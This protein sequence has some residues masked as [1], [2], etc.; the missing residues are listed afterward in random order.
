MNAPAF[1]PSCDSPA[2]LYRWTIALSE[3]LAQMRL[4]FQGD[5]DAFLIFLIF[6]ADTLRRSR[7]G[8]RSADGD[9]P[10]QPGGINA[11]SV[12]E[13]TGIP[14][15]TARRKLQSLVT[16]GCVVRD[17]SGLYQ[18]DPRFNL[19]SLLADLG[20][21]LGQGPTV[22]ALTGRIDKGQGNAQPELKTGLKRKTL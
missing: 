22:G 6:A 3:R 18:V 7:L 8:P 5:L 14:R 12:S 16:M 13:I 11:L 20:T 17:A 15:E 4:S 9:A 1:V 10:Q 2:A 21:V 19:E